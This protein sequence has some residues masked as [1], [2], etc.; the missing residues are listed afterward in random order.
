VPLL[1]RVL[2][3]LSAAADR[4][5]L[6]VVIGAFVGAFG[7]PAG[8][9]AARRGLVS[10]GVT[11][12]LVN[13]PLKLVWR[14][15]RPPAGRP[16][17]WV[18]P[19]RTFSFPSGHTASAF[20]FATGAGLEKPLLLLPLAALAAAVGYS[21]VRG[22]VHYPSDVL[23]GA[24]LGVAAALATGPLLAALDSRARSAAPPV[25]TRRVVLVTS[26]YSH[27]AARGLPLARAELRKRGFE[28]VEELTVEQA[29]RVKELIATAGEEP[30]LVIAAG[31]DGTVG[32]VANQLANTP[33]VL[34]VLPLG[35]SND[36]ARS[37]KIPMRISRA[38]ELLRSGKVATVDLGRLVPAGQGPLHF[39]HAAT[40]GLNV[41]F[42]KLATRASLRKR[43]GRL[44]Y[45]FAAVL[46]LEERR[47]FT[48]EIRYE[49]RSERWH[50]TH[51][52]V[53]NAPVFG[54][55]LGLR[56]PASSPDDR[57]LDV[58]AVEDLPVHRMLLAGVYQLLRI[59][60]PLKGVHALHV[61][62]MR[63]HC[64]EELEVALDGEVLGKLPADFVVAGEALRTI[65]P[66]DL[67]EVD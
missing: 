18:R 16:A 43:L 39:V 20:A 25:V 2:P 52:S 36:F 27:R 19:P 38:V 48:C 62:E 28:I 51:L 45:V 59:G 6:W 56:V 44:T 55:F 58:L 15:R 9:R 41:S 53:I 46:A 50:L 37:L 47:S 23:A 30:P 32:T 54:G 13:G 65:V 31:G 1:E 12:A 67:D 61:S 14:R 63:V 40:V 35:T 11:S 33:V 29:H 8:Q 64:D 60:R 3:V 17:P 7:G 34:G 42:A 5:L 57:L 10:L 22:R 4:S 49:G 26:P 21:R 66:A 24:G